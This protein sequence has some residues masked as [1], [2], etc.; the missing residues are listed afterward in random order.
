MAKSSSKNE[1][2]DDSLCSKVCKKNTDSLN[3]KITD[4]SE[5]LGDSKTMLYHYKLGLS[6]VEARLVEFKNQEIKFHEKIRGLEFSVESKNNKI[7]R[8]TKELDE[9]KK[10]KEGLDTKLIGLP[11]FADDTITDYTRPS[12]RIESNPN[13]LQNNSSSISEIGES[14]SSILSK[15]E[16]KFVKATDSPTVIKTNKD[17][18]VRK[19]FIKYA[20]LYRKTSKSSNV[21]ENGNSWPKNKYTHK[22]MPP[23]T[24][25]YKTDRSPAADSGFKLIAYADADHAGCNDDFKSTSRGISFLGEKLVSWS[26]KKQDC[27]AMS[28]AEAEYVSLSACCAQV[29]WM[30]T[31]LLDYGFYF[32][33]ISL[34]LETHENPFVSPANIH[35]IKAFMN[36]VG[37]QDVVD[38][39]AILMNQ[40]QLVVSTQGTNRNTPRAHRSLTVS[41]NPQEMKKRKQTAGESS[42]PRRIIKKKK[43]TTPSI[44]P[45]RDDRERDE[46]AKATLLSANVD[47]T[48]SKLE[49]KSQKENL[50]CVSDDDETEK[51]KE[52][53]QDMND[54]ENE[55]VGKEHNIVEKEVANEK[56]V[57]GEKTN[58]VVKEKAVANVSGSQE[59]R[60]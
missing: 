24:A 18:T 7:E 3:S 10:D 15:H 37:Y 51:E 43:Q 27:T 56:N 41:A 55:E 25:I 57:E 5:K 26:S 14:T 23:R 12:P 46:I 32:N 16:I 31:K 60:N 45:P 34:Y 49:P 17:E 29:I 58:D 38:K 20:K 35:T 59:I 8:L 44:L 47:N 30:R 40:P 19:P 53:E 4:L 11:E 50:E 28:S 13:D 22:S 33:K 1:V 54:K 39:V 9:L 2:F 48:G 21:R 36:R 6:Q 42:S 52:V